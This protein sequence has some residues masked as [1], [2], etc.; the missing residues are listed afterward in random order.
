[1]SDTKQLLLHLDQV[2]LAKT[3]PAKPTMTIPE[4]AFHLGCSRA[5]VYAYLDD[6]TLAAQ[7]IS[8][9]NPLDPGAI[10]RHRRVI[11]ASA[12]QFLRKRRTV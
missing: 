8:R 2:D 1:M 7:D 10:R 4:A 3:L 11:T 12:A 5:Q 6:G 9:K